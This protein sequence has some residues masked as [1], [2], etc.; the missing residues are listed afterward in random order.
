MP[1]AALLLLAAGAEPGPAF[2]TSFAGDLQL[3]L[4]VDDNGPPPGSP[5][6]PP[7]PL[8]QDP[9]RL[10]TTAPPPPLPPPQYP[11]NPAPAPQQGN[12]PPPPPQAYPSPPAPPQTY[13]PP[14]AP[15]QTY[16]PPAP[17]PSYAPPSQPSYAPA[18]TP[19]P[20]P[21]ADVG[22]RFMWGIG[23]HLGFG[24]DQFNGE[25][26]TAGL[27]IGLY[28]RAGDEINDLLGFEA[29]VSAGTVVFS[30]Y[31]RTALTLDI[32]PIDWFTFA[33]G[34]VARGDVV[35]ACTTTTATSVGGTVRFDFH[36]G[37]SRSDSGRGGFTIGLVGDL[38]AVVG[39]GGDDWFE[40]HRAGRGRLPDDWLGTLLSR[41]GSAD[42]PPSR[43]GPSV[44]RHPSRRPGPRRRRRGSAGRPPRP[45]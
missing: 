6:P 29:E 19:Q 18:A 21:T 15:Q 37:S 16:P 43:T 5:Y 30:S 38:G 36:I 24:E 35:V 9:W 7:P 14:Q 11:S 2:I 33:I 10:P 8:V 41:A 22:P 3:T 39:V 17:P 26:S 45:R 32:T 40:V 13:Y 27:G 23:A 4:A 34:P 1:L 44:S 20:A 42:A 31:L 12:P 25:E 28:L